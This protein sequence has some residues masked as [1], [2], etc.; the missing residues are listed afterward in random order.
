MVK[1]VISL[2][3]F[4]CFVLRVKVSVAPSSPHAVRWC[5]R[6]RIRHPNTVY[7]LIEICQETKP[8]EK[9]SSG[10]TARKFES[11]GRKQKQQ[12]QFPN[13]K[14][15][16][17]R[18]QQ[19][20]NNIHDTFNN[21]NDDVND[22]W[23]NR[24]GHEDGRSDTHQDDWTDDSDDEH[25]HFANFQFEIKKLSEM[26]SGSGQAPAREKTPRDKS[27]SSS[28][29]KPFSSGDRGI[30]RS[31]VTPRPGRDED[32]GRSDNYKIKQNVQSY[33]R[34]QFQ[35]RKAGA[36]T[37][38][39]GYE[40]GNSVQK[41]DSRTPLR[42]LRRPLT[43]SQTSGSLGVL[44]APAEF[45]AHTRRVSQQVYDDSDQAHF[46]FDPKP[47]SFENSYQYQN[48]PIGNE[49]QQNDIWNSIEK[50][51]TPEP[52]HDSLGGSARYPYPY[53]KPSFTEPEFEYNI[54]PISPVTY[55]E[56]EA[57]YK[58]NPKKSIRRT[59]VTQS[60]TNFFLDLDKATL[61][62]SEPKSSRAHRDQNKA[63]ASVPTPSKIIIE[64]EDTSSSLKER[65]RGYRRVENSSYRG[66]RQTE[67]GFIGSETHEQKVPEVTKRGYRRTE[68][69]VGGESYSHGV[70]PDHHGGLEAAVLA[71]AS[72]YK[73]EQYN[74]PQRLAFQIHGQ[75]GP[76]SY[77]FGH[78]TGVG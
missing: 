62:L 2:Y 75:Q 68:D 77:R 1:P 72:L 54:S 42:I 14:K 34:P 69:S 61:I 3:I 67:N 55:E 50:K 76:E 13:F 52:H 26:Y 78:D 23:N 4:F 25:Q 59:P 53:Q 48:N 60:P 7:L 47:N 45:Q 29:D 31:R 49:F 43:S 70:S 16:N 30:K 6:G 65:P 66:Y 63:A 11:F 38:A 56:P 39:P 44:P 33:E 21:W 10:R 19:Q 58:V 20:W 36:T 18:E 40:Y 57:V 64:P 73:A 32:M 9:L 15:Q 27:F 35:W 37:K 41:I 22:D 51:T 46:Q 8:E 74:Q 24:L 17:N 5:T 12:Q 71:G 28:G